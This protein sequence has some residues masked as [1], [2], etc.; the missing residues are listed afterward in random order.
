MLSPDAAT[1]HHRLVN[2][3]GT[4][5]GVRHLQAD[6]ILR[7]VKRQARFHDSAGRSA[8]QPLLTDTPPTLVIAVITWT[9]DGDWA[10]KTL[11]LPTWL[12]ALTW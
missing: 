2:D 11:T 9:A 7:T 8:R 5:P 1:L 3:I 12:L 6:P 10:T 4:I